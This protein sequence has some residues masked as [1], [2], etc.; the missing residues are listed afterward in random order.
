MHSQFG[1]MV[2]VL[3][4]IRSDRP[5]QK[6]G[7]HERLTTL[8]SLQRLTAFTVLSGILLGFSA[9]M[10][11]DAVTGHPPYYMSRQTLMGLL[12]GLIAPAMA[13]LL[14][15]IARYTVRGIALRRRS[16]YWP[17][18]YT[19]SGL[20]TGLVLM[21]IYQSLPT[22]PFDVGAAALIYPIAS[23]IIFV[24]VALFSD[25]YEAA[26]LQ[27][28][29]TRELFSRYVSGH[30]VD[31]L[32]ARAE[33]VSLSGERRHI[34]VLFSDIRGF[35]RLSHGMP[36][37]EVVAAL[38][39]YFTLM[40]DVVFQFG[41]SVDKFMGDGLMAL[42]GAPLATGDEAIRA[43]QASQE[44]HRQVQRFNETTQHRLCGPVSIGI[45]NVGSLRRLE[46]T[47]IGTVVNN[48]FY[49]S[50]VSGP[51]ETLLTQATCDELRN[52][53]ETVPWRTLV[54]HGAEKETQIYSTTTQAA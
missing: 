5:D 13:L 43:A 11:V 50:K 7:L 8:A 35:S 12:A 27:E 49:L 28:R 42:F 14:S 51:G 44:M 40:V 9:G 22:P 31:R 39:D 34:T 15:R 29:R 45:G 32:L 18:I 47:A 19:L 10:A 26:Y 4:R 17:A 38:N 16:A 24:P 20:L 6:D 21:A 46:Y 23:I 33:P 52:T 25:T 3:G 48:A 41:G 54:F 36:A 53:T 37:E 30:V 1:G 2:R